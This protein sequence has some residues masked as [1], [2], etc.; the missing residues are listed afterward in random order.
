[1]NKHICFIAAV[2]LGGVAVSLSVASGQS[3]YS[4]ANNGL[5]QTASNWTPSG[6][7]TGDAIINTA[8]NVF[9]TGGVAYTTG[10]V[11]VAN[12]TAAGAFSINMAA[13]GTTLNVNRLTLG[14]SVAGGF[15]GLGFTAAGTFSSTGNITLAPSAGSAQ[16]LFGAAGVLNVNGGAGSVINGGGTGEARLD[17]RALNSSIN[18]AN[19]G[20]DALYMGIGDTTASFTINSGQAYTASSAVFIAQGVAG[21]STLNMNGGSLTTPDFRLNQ[22]ASGSSAVFNLSGGTLNATTIERFNTGA[23]QT[24]NWNNGTI[25]NISTGNLTLT[26]G[27]GSASN[28]V[29]SL[30]GTGS[31]TFDISSGKNATVASTAI[32]ADKFGEN[33]TLSKAGAGTL[34]IN[35]V[36]TYTG[37]TTISAGTLVIASTGSIAS[38]TAIDLGTSGTLDVSAVSGGFHLASGQTLKGSGTVV[39]AM[40]VASGATLAI[41][42]SPGTVIF[43]NNLT[44]ASGSISNFEINGLTAGLYDLAQGG[45]GSQN[46]NFGGTLNLI[47]SAGFNTQGTVKIFDFET[48]SGNFTAVNISGLASG[49][50]ASF[51]SLTGVVTVVPE[52]STW[53]LLAGGSAFVVVLRSR[54][55]IA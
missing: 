2:A 33:G 35:S 46:V 21:T 15:S 5:W 51:D 8:T 38:S 18:A 47:F 20:L 25:S 48:Y 39:G 28:L 55:K 13:L 7:P 22:G 40:A 10:N 29:I 19:V 17:V 11:T 24:F 37:A 43:D 6:V 53:A 52:P 54:R 9:V 12:P 4:G 1:M 34:A 41:G 32:L 49:H 50:A 31:H 30:S 3:V 36:S 42:N 26:K 27:A 16:I 45:A 14:S 23:S 44:L